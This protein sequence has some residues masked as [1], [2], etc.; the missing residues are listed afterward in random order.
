[1]S[2]PNRE[3]DK[4]S[5]SINNAEERGFLH[6]DYIAHCLRWSHVVKFLMQQRNYQ[7]MPVMD[8]GCGKELPL[9]KL[10]YSS[11]M[12]GSV[13]Y[14]VDA[15]KLVLPEMLEVAVANRQMFI[16][17]FGQTLFSQIDFGKIKPYPLVFV[18][19]EVLEHMSPV[20]CVDFLK[21]LYDA[22]VPGEAVAFISTPNFNGKAAANHINELPYNVLYAILDQIGFRV[23]GVWGTFASQ[24]EIKKPLFDAFGM[25]FAYEQL[26]EYYD[27][28]LLSTLFA[29]LLPAYS[30]NCFWQLSR[31]AKPRAP[32]MSV[33]NAIAINIPQHKDTKSYLEIDNV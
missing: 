10:M 12:T 24:S 26:A 32:T 9:A 20:I 8:I 7:Q 17:L 14:G 25:K 11:R 27:S 30:R 5:L 33:A 21:R 23:D 29:P 16:R 31:P 28:N 1:M 6:R 22:M 13:Y 2:N 3:I 15:N 19:L 18:A 4:T